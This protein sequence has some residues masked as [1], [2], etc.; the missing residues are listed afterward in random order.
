M[1]VSTWQTENQTCDLMEATV[2]GIPCLVKVESCTIVSPWNGQAHTCPSS[3]DYYGYSEA[4][5]TVYDRKGYRAKWLE[6][7]LTGDDIERI[8]QEI[9]NAEKSR[10]PEWL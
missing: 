7:K 10:G 4:E 9:V 1:A 6:A 8:E 5:F 2:S 3:D